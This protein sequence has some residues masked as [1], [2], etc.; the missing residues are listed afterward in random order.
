MK[1]RVLALMGDKQSKENRTINASVV[2]EEVGLTRQVVSKWSRNEVVEF[3][4]DII[5]KFCQYFHVG[6]GDLLYMEE[7]DLVAE[8]N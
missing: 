4:S 5:V 2:A 1:N 8:P 3:R 6:I 7:S